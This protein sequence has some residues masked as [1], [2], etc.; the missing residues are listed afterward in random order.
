MLSLYI[1]AACDHSDLVEFMIQEGA[2]PTA[3]HQHGW[4]VLH[5]ASAFLSLASLGS[6]LIM[7]QIQMLLPANIARP[8]RY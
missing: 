8:Y 7:V 1:A 6:F 5:Y 2:N 3:V 4:L